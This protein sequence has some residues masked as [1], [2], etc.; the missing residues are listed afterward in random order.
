MNA[1]QI[2][3]IFRNLAGIVQQEV[4]KRMGNPHQQIRGLQR[5]VLGRAEKRLGDFQQTA[6]RAVRYI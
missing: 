6:K 3:G 2:H 4:G 5:Q 1:N